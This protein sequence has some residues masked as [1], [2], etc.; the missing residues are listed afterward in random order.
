MARQPFVRQR[1]PG[2]DPASL[3]NAD[4]IHFYGLYTGNY[5]SLEREK[6]LQLCDLLNKI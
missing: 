5:P 3:K 2:F 1:M 6:V 4:C